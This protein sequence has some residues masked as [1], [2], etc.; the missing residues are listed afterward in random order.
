MAVQV[1][2]VLKQVHR[3][4]A[5]R[6]QDGGGHHFGVDLG[7]PAK[8]LQQRALHM[9]SFCVF[10]GELGAVDFLQKPGFVIRKTGRF[11]LRHGHQGTLVVKFKN[12][13][14]PHAGVRS[15]R[16]NIDSVLAQGLL[17]FQPGAGFPDS[18]VAL[19]A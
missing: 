16:A 15:Q 12:T 4:H 14:I 3:T 7:G 9:R 19:V 10:A 2:D 5:F 11:A 17:F 13:H 18:H 6:S 8:R 1:L